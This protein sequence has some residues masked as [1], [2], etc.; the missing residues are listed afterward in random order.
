MTTL[1][2][3]FG[4]QGILFS[5]KVMAYAGLLEGREVSWLPSYGPEMRGGTANCGVCISSNPVGSP[6]VTDPDAFVVMNL[7]S[8]LKYI[9]HVRPGGVAVLDSFLIDRKVERNDIRAFYIPATRLASENK[10]DGLANMIM[11]GKLLRETQFAAYDSV[12]AGLR[13]SVPA[14]KAALVDANIKAIGIGMEYN[15]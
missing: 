1:F 7:P 10:I 13:K 6:L 12:I 11:L 3:G 14:R 2:A 9:D 8:F 5:G 15:K 4:G